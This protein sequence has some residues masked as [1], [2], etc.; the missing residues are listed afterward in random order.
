MEHRELAEGEK[1]ENVVLEFRPKPEQ[2]MVIACLWNESP[3]GDEALLL[4]PE[5]PVCRRAS[6]DPR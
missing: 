4:E 6:G 5:H 2:D 3:D 1:S